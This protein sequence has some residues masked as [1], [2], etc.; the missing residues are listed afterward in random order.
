MRIVSR[1]E[2]KARLSKTPPVMVP[3]RARDATCVHHDGATP[4]VVRT[5]ADACALVR[6][7]QAYHQDSNGW[8]DIGYNY[9]VISAP[10][11]P[12]D[13]LIFEG[14]GRD[15]VGAHCLN[16]N[17]AWVGIQVA[18][19]GKQVPSP[20]ALA[21]VRWLHDT[22][23]AAAGHDLARKT[24]SDGFNTEC[25]GPILQAWVHAGMPVGPPNPSPA[26]S[27]TV[28]KAREVFT[29]R[30][31]GKSPNVYISDG[32][33]KRHIASPAQLVELTKIFDLP[34]T[35]VMAQATLDAIPEVK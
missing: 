7:D 22:A 11:T 29:V 35:K 34:P 14:R 15:A 20:A 32:V 31:T 3:I 19:G 18:I 17:E 24:H 33:T 28:R 26:P 10:G 8:A 5:F 21:S 25:P 12:V 2:W 23:T 4:I 1:K 27:T 13:G 6:R 16:H 30:G 9:L